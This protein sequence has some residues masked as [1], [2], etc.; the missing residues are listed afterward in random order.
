MTA[1][2]GRAR[3]LLWPDNGPR[4]A[5]P[6][7]I[8]AREH[9][10][11]CASCAAFFEEMSRLSDDVRRS[12]A[13]TVAPFEVRERLFKAISRARTQTGSRFRPTA[14]LVAAGASALILM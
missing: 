6:E 9:V 10:E 7:V 13:P 1:E 5:T 11:D 14:A 4:S 3:R 12:V 2:C 8:E